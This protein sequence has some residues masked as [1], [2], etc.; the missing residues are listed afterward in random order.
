MKRTY[1]VFILELPQ[2]LIISSDN[3]PGR[4]HDQ[5]CVYVCGVTLNR[6]FCY[7]DSYPVHPYFVPICFPPKRYKVYGRRLQ[8]QQRQLLMNKIHRGNDEQTQEY[9]NK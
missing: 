9:T 3:I 7:S 1:F 6:S 5:H 4:H 2:W 8:E